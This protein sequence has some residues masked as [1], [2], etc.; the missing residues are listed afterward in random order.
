MKK[1]IENKLRKKIRKVIKEKLS[2]S[3]LK[4]AKKKSSDTYERTVYAANGNQFSFY[5]Q[6]DKYYIVFHG[7]KGEE[8][9]HIDMPSSVNKHDKA[10][11]YFQSFI[12]NYN[13]SKKL[14]EG[15]LTEWVVYA[16]VDKFNSKK[17]D[18]DQVYFKDDNL[19]KVLKWA[20]KQQPKL[21]RK[22][23]MSLIQV[24][25]NGKMSMYKGQVGNIL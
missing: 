10:E 19:Q 23:G 17:Q 13:R 4:K 1:I 9:K 22:H 7:K 3:I 20:K 11:K 21:W 16:V 2:G 18:Y 14:P 6:D 25:K 12:K 8:T 24:G 15:K 5:D